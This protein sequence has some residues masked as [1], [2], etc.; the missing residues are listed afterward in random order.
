MSSVESY[1][2]LTSPHMLPSV[3]NPL[4]ATFK[5]FKGQ[6][7]EFSEGNSKINFSLVVK[8]V[9][10]AALVIS[11]AY[12]ASPF[13]KLLNDS[14][15]SQGSSVSSMTK[16]QNQ[17]P[18][19]STILSSIPTDLYKKVQSSPNECNDENLESQQNRKIT[20][21]SATT[22]Q[23]QGDS[24]SRVNPAYLIFTTVI[25]GGIGGAYMKWGK[26][27]KETLY[28]PFDF[29]FKGFELIPQG[30]EVS[31]EEQKNVREV[32]EIPVPGSDE[33]LDQN[34]KPISNSTAI[35]LEEMVIEDE[36]KN[37]DVER[38]KTNINL[39]SSQDSSRTFANR[40]QSIEE[41]KKRQK[42]AKEE[43]LLQEIEEKT[44]DGLAA[45]AYA[46]KNPGS[47]KGLSFEERET[48]IAS[49]KFRDFEEVFKNL[50]A[51]ANTSFSEMA[52]R[53]N[54]WIFLDRMANRSSPYQKIAREA[55]QMIDQRSLGNP[56]E[57]KSE[58]KYDPLLIL[59]K[60]TNSF[61][62]SL[63]VKVRPNSQ[64]LIAESQALL[65]LIEKLPDPKV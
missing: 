3:F 49:Q 11:G 58:I 15:G 53:Q 48:T 9:G 26:G 36:A 23:P 65:K 56:E 57:I 22:E 45:L 4:K 1:R 54:I 38:E 50:A 39:D 46:Q 59:D 52:F 17:P 60:L 34:D 14:S 20:P 43:K 37:R 8:S 28:S 44:I 31:H 32:P 25:L 7:K 64:N 62:D 47:T 41:E 42:Q 51:L 21:L 35:K 55:I 5:N 18:D 29:E 10:L 16:D 2:G 40:T 13:K 63:Q 27:A 30:V 61:M 24:N 33:K 12:L 6:L 19:I